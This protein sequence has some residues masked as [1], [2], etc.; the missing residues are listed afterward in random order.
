MAR[1]RELRP[2]ALS[3]RLEISTVDGFQGREK[4]AIVISMVGGWVGRLG[5]WLGREPA[6]GVAGW[7]AS[8]EGE[9]CDPHTSGQT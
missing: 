1:L 5:S 7:P 3:S 6:S 2:E 4:E 8:G 9:G